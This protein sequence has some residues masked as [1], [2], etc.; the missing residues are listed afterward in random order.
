MFRLS[1]LMIGKLGMSVQDSIDE[2]QTVS[3]K[4]FKDGRHHRGKMSKGFLLPRYCGKRFSKTIQS[5]FERKGADSNLPMSTID[6]ALNDFT[7]W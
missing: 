3:K 2:Y 6:T 1:A 5:L 7:H 4:I